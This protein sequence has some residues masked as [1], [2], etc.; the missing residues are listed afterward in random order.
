MLFPFSD[1]GLNIALRKLRDIVFIAYPWFQHLHNFI[2][3]I[4][5]AFLSLYDVFIML[6]IH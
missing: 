4:D 5:D 2:P 3:N 6:F 1:D